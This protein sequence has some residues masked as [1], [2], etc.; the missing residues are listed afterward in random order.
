MFSI[1]MTSLTDTPLILQWE[2]WLWSLLGLKGLTEKATILPQLS[3]Y[4]HWRRVRETEIKSSQGNLFT[5]PLY[6]YD[7]FQAPM[8][9][10]L[11]T[12]YVDLPTLGEMTLI[13]REGWARLQVERLD[14]RQTTQ[15]C[16]LVSCVRLRY[17]VGWSNQ[18]TPTE[19]IAWVKRFLRKNI[20][21]IQLIRPE[22]AVLFF[23][24]E[25]LFVQVMFLHYLSF[26][27]CVS[28]IVLIF[29]PEFL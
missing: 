15:L 12:V 17:R 9:A 3:V 6:Y 7:L 10:R 11:R 29:L 2:V 24:N 16:G 25:F 20:L 5:H 21:R 26:F 22:H 13:G 19:W 8:T 4:S 14:P 18:F 27:V 28:V 1:L 23:W